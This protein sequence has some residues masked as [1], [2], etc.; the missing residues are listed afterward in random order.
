MQIRFITPCVALAAA[1]AAGCSSMQSAS[2]K[3]QHI[4]LAQ[5][6]APARLTIE[7][8]TAGGKIEDIVR[9]V[10]RGKLVYDVE[11]NVGG[12]HLEWLVA[13][14]GGAILGTETQIELSEA[15]GPV[16]EAAGK[17]FGTSEGLLAMRGLGY[18]ETHYE[19]EGR[20]DGRKV[21]VTFAPDGS[22]AE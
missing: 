17:F 3:E 7:R 11:G 6:S 19:V 13:D 2:Q 21:E 5:M 4:T 1:L 8:E 20:K 16:R 9:E 22:R 10:E 12:K 14:A 18:G 15:P